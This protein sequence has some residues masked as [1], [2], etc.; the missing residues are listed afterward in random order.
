M[1]V[2]LHPTLRLGLIA[3]AAPFGVYIV[4]LGLGIIPFFQ[5]QYGTHHLIPRVLANDV[6][7]AFCMHTR[8]TLSGGTTSISLSNGA[9][10]VS[11]GLDSADTRIDG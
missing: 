7:I 8:F 5:R 6:F 4:F 10:L 9:S 1:A 11:E 3:A 2:P